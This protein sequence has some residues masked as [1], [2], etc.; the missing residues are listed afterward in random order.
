MVYQ[1]A[2]LKF[3]PT[4]SRKDKIEE[5]VPRLFFSLPIHSAQLG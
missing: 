1:N 5:K 4:A 2:V 3:A